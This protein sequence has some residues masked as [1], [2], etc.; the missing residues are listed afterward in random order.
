MIGI[1]NTKSHENMFS[2]ED[3]TMHLLFQACFLFVKLQET[4]VITK[5]QVGNG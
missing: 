3:I 1:R 4:G 5:E 2:N